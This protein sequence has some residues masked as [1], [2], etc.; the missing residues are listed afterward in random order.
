MRNRLACSVAERDPVGAGYY[1]TSEDGVEE[2]GAKG[3]WTVLR[4]QQFF[5]CVQLISSLIV[6]LV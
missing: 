3:C 2:T 6:D 5:L 4:H 1:S